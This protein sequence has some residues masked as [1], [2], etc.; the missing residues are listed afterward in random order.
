M[1]CLRD[2]K[3]NLPPQSVLL[4]SSNGGEKILILTSEKKKQNLFQEHQGSNCQREKALINL[5]GGV[6]ASAGD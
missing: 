1:C 5:P 4:H 2:D 6:Q 3:Q